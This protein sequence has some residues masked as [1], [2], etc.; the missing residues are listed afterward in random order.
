[1][2]MLNPSDAADKAVTWTSSDEKVVTISADGKV[3]AIAIG[4]AQVT[5]TAGGVTSAPVT[6]TVRSKEIPASPASDEEFNKLEE[7][8]KSEDDA[9]LDEKD[10]T[11]DSWGPYQTAL[12]NAKDVLGNRQSASEQVQ[13]AL[14][15][16]SAAKQGLTKAS[17]GQK[18]NGGQGSGGSAKPNGD[19]DSSDAG[20]TGA[21]G[22]AVGTRLSATGATVVGVSF[23]AAALLGTGLALISYRRRRF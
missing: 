21:S 3:T 12:D 1:M 15:A 7:A 5:A 19:A 10:Y 4:T 22:T 2:Y 13:A 14:A 6:V 20:K 18:P 9:K 11:A 8:I 17:S 16:L 23:A